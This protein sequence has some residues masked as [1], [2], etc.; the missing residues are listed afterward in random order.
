MK[1]IFDLT[2]AA[3]LK[4]AEP[5]NLTYN[6]INIIVWYYLIPLFWAVLLD[7][8]LRFPLVTPIVAAVLCVTTFIHR[9][10][11]SGFCDTAFQ[12]SVDFLLLF[13]H[14]RMN[15]VAASV[16]VCIVVPLIITVILLLLLRKR[17][18]GPRTGAPSRLPPPPL[19]DFPARPEAPY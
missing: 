16:V 5:F 13:R 3:L 15:Y 7:L 14:I 9:K 2:V 12:K 8:K 17:R 11:F 19:P 1:R 4:I 6:E 18:R 10:D